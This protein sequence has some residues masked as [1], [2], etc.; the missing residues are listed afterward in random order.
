MRMQELTVEQARAV[1]ESREPL[2]LF[3]ARERDGYVGIDNRNG[4]AF[5]ETFDTLEECQRWLNRE[6]A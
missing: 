3:W 4:D 1:V 2:G 5:V 6:E